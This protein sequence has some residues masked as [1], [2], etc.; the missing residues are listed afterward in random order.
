MEIDFSAAMAE[1]SLLCY[2]LDVGKMLTT[3]PKGLF[4][5]LKPIAEL[6]RLIPSIG[7]IAT[8]FA[9]E[10]EC[11]WFWSLAG[12]PDERVRFDKRHPTHSVAT[13]FY[14][15]FFPQDNHELETHIRR[16]QLGQCSM[17]K[18]ASIKGQ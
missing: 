1:I 6:Y 4:V 9:V 7:Q 13:P 14:V 8:I 5:P 11:N 10:L 15:G 18:G 2:W 3:F 17:E 16:S 12:L